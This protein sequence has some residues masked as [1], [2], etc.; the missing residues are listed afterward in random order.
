MG[1]YVAFYIPSLI[2]HILINFCINCKYLNGKLTQGSV[3][4]INAK[5]LSAYFHEDV[6]RNMAL[7]TGFLQTTVLES[8][9][10]IWF[11]RTEAKDRQIVAQ[12]YAL[13]LP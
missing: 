7:W 3:V 9:G 11:N 5:I 13:S 6:F 10:C 1:R 4:C 2:E 8:L 12:K